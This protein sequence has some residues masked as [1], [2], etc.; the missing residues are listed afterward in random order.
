MCGPCPAADESGQYLYIW[1][2]YTQVGDPSTSSAFQTLLNVPLYCQPVW[3]QKGFT[4]YALQA[5]ANE[6]LANHFLVSERPSPI[7]PELANF[8]GGT[9]AELRRLM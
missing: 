5:L 6:P 3:Q 4:V 2:T 9:A 8:L 7:L 1:R